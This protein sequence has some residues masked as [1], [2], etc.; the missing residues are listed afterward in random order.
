VR[1]CY[2]VISYVQNHFYVKNSQL[3]LRH[4]A[5]VSTHPAAKRPSYH[6][7][8]HGTCQTRRLLMRVW[9]HSEGRIGHI[10]QRKESNHHL[11]VPPCHWGVSPE[12]WQ[13]WALVQVRTGVRTSTAIHI[14]LE[15]PLWCTHVGRR[16]LRNMSHSSNG[17]QLL[18]EHQST[19]VASRWT[20]ENEG[21]ARSSRRDRQL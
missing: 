13:Q 10:Y 19:P 14:S 7:R 21:N 18:G 3:S 12:T 8:P 16:T 4:W 15:D 1:D 6:G 20:R 5:R 9:H 2:D 11:H 17:H